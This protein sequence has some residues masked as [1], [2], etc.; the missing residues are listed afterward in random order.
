[1]YLSYK[2][3]HD[4]DNLLAVRLVADDVFIV[5][6]FD[7]IWWLKPVQEIVLVQVENGVEGWQK[8][9]RM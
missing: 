6:G 8:L 3:V 4:I 7:R 5:V 1:M 9:S 2:N